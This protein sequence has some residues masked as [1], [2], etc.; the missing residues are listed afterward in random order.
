MSALA[1]NFK[2]KFAGLLRGMLRR[3]DSNDV[4]ESQTARPVTTAAPPPTAAAPVVAPTQ[5]IPAIAPAPP[6]PMPMRAEGASELE[7]PLLPILEKLPPDLRS[8]WT[9]G[10]VNLSEAN[11][12]ISVDKVLPQLAQGT[13]KITFGEL[14][15]AAPNLFRMGEEYDSLPIV[16]PLNDVLARLNPAMLI[17]NQPQK[18]VTAPSEISGP[19]GTGGQGVMFTTAPLKPTPPTTHF[20]KK[21]PPA[22]PAKIQMS[23]P[24]A[25]PPPSFT[26]RA[27]TPAPAAP[28]APIPL[29]A[30]TPAPVTQI[31]SPARGPVA[32]PIPAPIPAA[33]KL[34]VPP[35]PTPIPFIKPATPA[36]ATPPPAPVPPMAMASAAPGEIA[37]ISVPMRALAEAWPETLRQEIVQ[38]NLVNS[39]VALPVHLIEP[40]LKRGRIIFSWHN[41]RSW[42]RPTPPGPSIHD[43][44][45]LELPLKVI[46][47]LFLPK[48]NGT[49]NQ[50]SKAIVP[51][52]SVP[53][54]FFGFPQP[55]P[56]EL[57]A[58]LNVPDLVPPVKPAEP[59]VDTNYFVR[60][61]GNEA[62]RE[63]EVDYRRPAPATDFTS[64]RAMPQD[65]IERAMKLPS[66]AGAI[67]ALPDGLKVA[68][69]LPSELN[70]D[71]VAAF[72]PQLFSR[73]SQCSKEL[74]M[75][76]LNNLNF[77][78]GNIPWKIFRVNAVYFAAFG[79]AGE[80]LPTAQLA[81]LAGELDRKK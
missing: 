72:L 44:K 29:R 32:T 12:C 17:R 11:I 45:E 41:L 28:A 60:A 63:D 6:A 24:V 77:T 58:P 35:P 19:F 57:A 20:F 1:N 51:P 53:N 47:P 36:M 80:P 74:R 55:Q 2:T 39:Q 9:M 21:A 27:T 65:I 59:K 69:H 48:Q 38:N 23:T 70:A 54:L 34:A 8:K 26:P 4:A 56:E 73:V 5:P 22:E 10:G 61:E 67:I 18:M 64:R 66:M 79:R 15:S 81:V 76:E 78:I 14:R 25:P 37:T 71:T 62:P 68:H 31:P 13:V 52:S 42:I 33:P 7:M 75:G 40:A 49:V 50:R 3:V 30:N 43:N 16:L 46:A